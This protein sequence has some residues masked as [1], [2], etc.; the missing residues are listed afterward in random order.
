MFCI[1]VADLKTFYLGLFWCTLKYFRLLKFY[2]VYLFSSAVGTVISWGKKVVQ[3]TVMPEN[4]NVLLTEQAPNTDP[5]KVSGP[6]LRL[7]C[8]LQRWAGIPKKS[9]F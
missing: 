1:S 3:T 2:H 7:K 6:R 8:P 9:E 5:Q 4:C